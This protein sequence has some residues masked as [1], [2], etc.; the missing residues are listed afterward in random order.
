[1]DW[2]CENNSA[3][4]LIKLLG[5]DAND[6]TLTKNSI[7]TFIDLVWDHYQKAIFR[8]VLIPYI[9]QAVS[10]SLLASGVIGAYIDM[11]DLDLDHEDTKFLKEGFRYSAA[12]LQFISMVTYLYF[13][14]LESIAGLFDFLDYCT[15]PWNIVDFLIILLTT[16]FQL[17]FS[18]CCYYEKEIVS[19]KFQRSIGSFLVFFMGIKVFYWMRLFPSYAYYVKLIQ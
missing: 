1:M 4:A 6:L 5:T 8:W 7:K 9:A 15:D 2:L 10:M 16:I 18:I 12:V 19:V 11:F 13:A 17:Q 3:R 14:Y